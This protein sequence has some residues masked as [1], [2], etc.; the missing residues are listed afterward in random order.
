[1]TRQALAFQLVPATGAV[2]A[3]R[4]RR[5]VPAHRRD[6]GSERGLWQHK[7][8]I[9]SGR[10]GIT[11]SR[12]ATGPGDQYRGYGSR[13]RRP[14]VKFVDDTGYPFYDPF[15]PG[16]V[17]FISLDATVVGH[18]PESRMVWLRQLLD[19]HGATYQRRVVFSYL[20]LW[21][22]AREREH[23]FIGDP[24]LQ[25]LPEKADLELYLSGHHHTF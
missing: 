18:L 4:R 25:A 12:I 22:L 14:D 9:S 17:L 20:P 16:D 8:R 21:P 6:L 2:S 3:V 7:L 13:P 23:E 10:C 15:S 19:K 5:T 11:H 24:E 1:M